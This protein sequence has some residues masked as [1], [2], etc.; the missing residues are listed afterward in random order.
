[1]VVKHDR[2]VVAEKEGKKTASAKQPKLKPN[3]EKSSKPASAPKPKAT[4]ERPSKASTAKPPKPNPVKEKSTRPHYQNKPTRRWTSVTKEAST[5]P[6]AQAQDDT[7]VNIV[8]NLPSPADTETKTGVASEKANNG[9][10]NE[11]L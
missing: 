6:Y 4:K 10:E 2:K 1:M 5:G 9:D 8:R 7:S 3:V 11:I